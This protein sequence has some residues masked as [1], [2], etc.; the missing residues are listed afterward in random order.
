[1]QPF[2][3]LRF[4]SPSQDI[5]DTF[6]QPLSRRSPIFIVVVSEKIPSRVADCNP[7]CM[8]HNAS[9]TLLA[10]KYRQ[11]TQNPISPLG[12]TVRLEFP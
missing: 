8:M 9:D 10:M 1:M 6:G 12:I 3:D 5:P 2:S 7:S 4:F 11:L